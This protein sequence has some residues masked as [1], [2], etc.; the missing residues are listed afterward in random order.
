MTEATSR[1]R[2]IIFD[3]NETLS[4]MSPLA[5]RFEAVGA[6]RHLAPTWFAGL[7]RDGFALTVTGDN[8]GFAALGSESLRGILHD[9]VTD[10]DPAVDHIMAGFS[11]LPVHPDVVDGVRALADLGITLVTLSNGATSVAQ[12]LFERNGIED[13]FERLLSVQDADRW[14]PAATAYA[15]ALRTMGVEASDAMLVA[16]HPWDIHGARDAGL[17]TCWLNRRGGPYP[18][19][20]ADADV[21]A[22]SL[23]DLAARLAGLERADRDPSGR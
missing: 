2:L 20:F 13:A 4:D 7:L 6:P 18:E 19:Y 16:V 11:A 8:P 12:G 15:Y 3:V 9:V 23:T 21:V 5:Q 17:A 10:V 22:S 14:K 1:P